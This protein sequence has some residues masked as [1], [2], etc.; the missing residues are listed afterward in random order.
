MVAVL[1]F[2]C[3]LLIYFTKT[4]HP[5][6]IIIMDKATF[7][8]IDANFNRAREALRVV[9][10]YCRFVLS[11]KTFSGESK[12]IRH[13]LSSEISK[14]DHDKL[15]AARD[16]TS[17]VGIGQTVEKQLYRT[18]LTDCFIANSKRLSEALRVLS[19]TCRP[20]SPAIA[21]TLEQLRYR[22]YK[23]EKD[24]SLWSSP[25]QKFQKVRL[26]ILITSSA[27]DTVL[28]LIKQ[29][30][31]GGADC[32]QLRAKNLSDNKLLILAKDFVNCC[33]ENNVL[34][35]INDRPDIAILAKADG[36][37]VGQTD[38]AIAEIRKISLSPMIIGQSTHSQA[39]L[40]AAIAEQA[41]YIGVGP[42]FATRTKANAD[43]VG[44]NYVKEACKNLQNTGIRAVAIGGITLENVSEV[45]KAGPQAIAVCS[46]ICNAP[47]PKQAC[48][49]FKNKINQDY[50]D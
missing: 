10:E 42:V 16:T 9:E 30:A 25:N 7:R 1:F 12:Q 28:D 33:Q 39:Q 20:I 41:S 35:I 47:N 48:Q 14:L 3:N 19:E 36:A 45:L 8:I 18:S 32:I 43:I 5:P 49:A 24:V 17:D 37:H 27:R 11:N 13:E 29:C 23:L 15:I 4:S 21:E 22:A 38:L 34:S 50:G 2:V 31:A 6:I 40:A 44:L 46:A 26:Y